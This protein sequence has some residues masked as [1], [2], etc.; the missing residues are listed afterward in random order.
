VGLS[1]DAACRPAGRVGQ[2]WQPGRAGG[3]ATAALQQDPCIR[4]ALREL[5]SM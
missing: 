2:R 3:G 4:L 1:P 5:R